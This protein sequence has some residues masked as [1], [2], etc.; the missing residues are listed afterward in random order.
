MFLGHTTPIDLSTRISDGLT[1][2]DLSKQIQ[3]SMDGASVYWKL[4][5]E[6]KKER[7]EAGLSKLIHI[8]SCNL[9]GTLQSP[10]ES[11]SWNLK[12]IMKGIYQVLKDS[13]GRCEDYISI[14]KSGLST[15]VL[16][17]PVSKH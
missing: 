6:I 14:T 7:E 4:L 16:P 12:S 2:L 10:T 1:D 17:Y 8:G 5:S 9:D 11:I 3:L 15:A 13:P